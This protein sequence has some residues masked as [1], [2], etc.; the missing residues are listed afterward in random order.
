MGEIREIIKFCNNNS[1]FLNGLYDLMTL[2]VVVF[3]LITIFQNKRSMGIAEKQTENSLRPIIIVDVESVDEHTPNIQS[4]KIKNVGNAPA[5]VNEFKIKGY[6][7]QP[8]TDEITG[9]NEEIEVELRFKYV[10]IL[11]EGEEKIIIIDEKLNPNKIHLTS[12]KSGSKIET[13][14]YSILSNKKYTNRCEKVNTKFRNY[15][16]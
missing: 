2:L 16:I 11:G 12:N 6:N 1:G 5:Q 15:E 13:T 4:I 7:H 14:Y 3:T 8:L 10:D 9:P